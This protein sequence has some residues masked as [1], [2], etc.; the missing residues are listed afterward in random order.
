MDE[1][2]IE[3]FRC[4]RERQTARLAPLTLLVGD[5]STGK[6][7]LLAMLRI[8]WR[9]VVLEEKLPRF[10]DEL[11]DLGTFR[12]VVHQSV[13]NGGLEQEFSGGFTIGDFTSEVKI[14]QGNVRPE[15][16][17]LLIKN[18][19]AS[20]SF[21]RSEG[22]VTADFITPNIVEKYNLDLSDNLNL[23]FARIRDHEIWGVISFYAY[24]SN[25]KSYAN[26]DSPL[27]DEDMN[28]LTE[29]IVNPFT[30]LGQR[31]ENSNFSVI[32]WANAPVR[33][34]PLR[35]YDP[36]TARLDPEG[37]AVP[38]L[39]AELAHSDVE[40]WET[41]KNAMESIGQ[42]TG[43]FDEINIRRLGDDL[44]SDPFQI[45]VRKT[46]GDGNGQW[47]NLIDVGYGV[48]Q[49]LPIIYVL[50]KM[51]ESFM[52][53]LQQPELH[54]HPSAQAGLGSMLCNVATK[55]QILVETHSDHLIDRVRM[56][57]RDQKYGIKPEDVSILYFERTADDVQIHNIRIDEEGNILDPPSSYRKFFRN[58]VNRSLGI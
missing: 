3:N 29:L 8:L 17:R 41:L 34:K 1:V 36:D 38:A 14:R 56:D 50:T 48:S 37:K 13:N 51:V 12:E 52:L 18:S 6:T 55:R 22:K 45:Q 33:S 53:M 42:K 40:Q 28:E 49:I 23:E 26:G 31:Y 57:V 15:V 11:F 43:M 58:E 5:N 10:K 9:A 35:T 54:L 24:L 27:N 47:R 32:P 16:S 39:L 25:K 7:S 19:T 2:T 44:S 46:S 21:S 20:V 4:F 30:L